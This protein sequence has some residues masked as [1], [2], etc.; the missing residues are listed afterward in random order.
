M[1]IVEVCPTTHW[2]C[3]QLRDGTRGATLN[4]SCMSTAGIYYMLIGYATI[5]WWSVF[6]FENQQTSLSPIASSIF[7]LSVV[8]PDWDESFFLSGFVILTVGQEVVRAHTDD[9]TNIIHFLP[10]CLDIFRLLF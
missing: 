2:F 1:T 4:V 10:L 3:S 7:H 6:F 9:M 5:Q 8:I